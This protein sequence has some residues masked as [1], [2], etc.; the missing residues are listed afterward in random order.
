MS[1]R[2]VCNRKVHVVLTNAG[3]AG[4]THSGH[5]QAIM[6]CAGHMAVGRTDERARAL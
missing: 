2:L 4:K 5:S 1:F 3:D 6:R